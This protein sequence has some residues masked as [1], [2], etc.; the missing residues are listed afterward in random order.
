MSLS[1]SIAEAVPMTIGRVGFR[2][3]G[4]GR[5]G[6]VVGGGPSSTTVF[7]HSNVLLKTNFTPFKVP[8]CCTFSLGSTLLDSRH[9]SN[10]MFERVTS[11]NALVSEGI[12]ASKTTACGGVSV[13]KPG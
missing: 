11:K 13:V 4:N 7:P 10:D 8:M 6:A 2:S 1:K 5:N 3:Q 12:Y 9:C